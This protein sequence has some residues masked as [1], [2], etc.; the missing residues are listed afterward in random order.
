MMSSSHALS[1]HLKMCKLVVEASVEE[2]TSW[3]DLYKLLP[4]LRHALACTVCGCIIEE[5][6]S[7]SDQ[8][9]QHSVCKSCVGGKKRLKPSCSYC[10]DYQL[11]VPNLQLKLIVDAFR[12]TCQYLQHTKIYERL[13]SFSLNGGKSSLVE[14]IQEGADNEQPN[15]WAVKED[16]DTT[17]E[18]PVVKSEIVD[19]EHSSNEGVSYHANIHISS[20]VS[21]PLVTS[22]QII[23]SPSPGIQ[24]QSCP[25][26]E[27]H[28]AHQP[29]MSH[30]P[31]SP[32]PPSLPP[33]PTSTPVSHPFYSMFFSSDGG[34]TAKLKAPSEHPNHHRLPVAAAFS[35][36]AERIPSRLGPVGGISGS[37][38]VPR[39][40][41]QRGCRCGNATPTPGKLTCCGQRC[42]CYVESRAC[43]DCKCRGCR[44]PHR[45]GGKKVR[46]H[47]PNQESIKVHELH[48]PL[49]QTVVPEAVPNS[50][51]PQ[52]Q[53]QQQQPQQPVF[54]PMR[55]DS[56]HHPA[57]GLP[58]VHHVIHMQHP[59]FQAPMFINTVPVATIANSVFMTDSSQN[60]DSIEV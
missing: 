4:Q 31:P 5:P 56:P 39:K 42:P 2:S 25:S 19:S 36:P 11:Y 54:Q 20:Q 43:L 28:F 49:H 27:V 21:M 47:I 6:R 1:L 58:P 12:K 14:L 7:P 55:I 17:R 22:P 46:P 41:V 37:R 52:Q 15:E 13:N 8:H 57:G 9:C 45:P 50:Q 10:K 16:G 33:P 26:P 3:G 60:S 35:Q 29:V 23:P 32:Q 59:M 18:V 30:V 48:Q 38:M 53:Q 40:K 44:N 51:Q 34:R 24:S